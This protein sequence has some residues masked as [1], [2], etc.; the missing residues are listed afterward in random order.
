MLNF[1]YPRYNEGLLTLLKLKK[2]LIILYLIANPIVN[3]KSVCEKYFEGNNIAYRGFRAEDPPSHLPTVSIEFSTNRTYDGQF[4]PTEKKTWT[5]WYYHFTDWKKCET[6]YYKILG[7]YKGFKKDT[8]F[9]DDRK[10][11]KIS[12]QDRG[13]YD[14]TWYD[15]NGEYWET[16]GYSK[17][18]NQ[19]LNEQSWVSTNCQEYNGYYH[20]SRWVLYYQFNEVLNTNWAA[21]IMVRSWYRII[22]PDF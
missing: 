10:L 21:I 13:Y 9:C 14:F 16:T 6:A 20:D 11:F 3:A 5:E 22:K 4:D 15:R 18:Y 17:S 1:E 7:N 8:F 2:L 19:A 12:K